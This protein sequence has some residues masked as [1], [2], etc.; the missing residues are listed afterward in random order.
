MTLATTLRK[1]IMN[2]TYELGAQLPTEHQ[3]CAR[4]DVSRHTARAALQVLEDASLIERRP[5]LGTRV[6]AVTNQAAF[7]Q[8]LG[9]LD[10]LLQY[11]RNAKLEIHNHDIGVLSQRDGKRLGAKKG[12]R[13]L[14][15]RGVR[16]VKSKAVAAATIYVSA[17]IKAKPEELIDPSCAII[18][19]IE[20][21]YG[22][23]TTTITQTIKAEH[24]NSEDAKTLESTVGEAA[25]CTIRRYYDASNTLILISDTRHA[26]DRFSYEM[27][28]K[29][30]SQT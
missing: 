8:P 7:S 10:D 15:L 14:I 2:G 12:S 18:Q 9:N 26:S 22:I 28:Y 16:T 5:G 21:L 3:L 23:S 6:T 25:L 17:D 27:S 4:Y 24:L 29:R 11:A 1:L 13:W 19:H 20:R 30:E